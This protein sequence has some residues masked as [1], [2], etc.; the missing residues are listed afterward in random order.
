MLYLITLLLVLN[1]FKDKIFWKN[2]NFKIKELEKDVIKLKTQLE[3]KDNERNIIEKN[4]NKMMEDKDIKIN[5]LQKEAKDLR[6]EN[7]SLKANVEERENA[8]KEIEQKLLE[9]FKNISSEVVEKQ[10]KNFVETQE[11]TLK[12][13]ETPFKDF[14]EQIELVKNKMEEVKKDTS[15]VTIKLSENVNRFNNFFTGTKQQG[16]FGEWQFEN[17]LESVGLKK[18]IDYTTQQGQNNEFGEKTKI[19]D[20]IINVGKEQKLLIDVKFPFENYERY[21]KEN[22][23]EYLKIYYNNIRTII[24][25]VAK[26]NYEKIEG[27]LDFIIVYLPLESAFYDLIKYDKTIIDYAYKRK[28]MILTG[29]S[30]LSILQMIIQLRNIEKQNK[31]IEKIVEYAITIHDKLADFTND[32]ENIGKNLD[33][34][35]E[36]YSEALKMI[37]GKGG[38]KNTAE[39]IKDLA[40]KDKTKKVISALFDS[41]EN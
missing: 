41:T 24:D 15:V 36:N 28:I 1:L 3:N 32:I 25:D 8:F 16:K 10:S 29:S 2:D 13:F 4:Y 31:N 19:P 18:D 26:R 38:V 12:V 35:K 22:N 11:Q 9:K 17:L 40:G 27:S 5:N 6:T 34:A 14:K 33:K 23:E 7:G 30:I 37:R 39:K 21:C 20:F